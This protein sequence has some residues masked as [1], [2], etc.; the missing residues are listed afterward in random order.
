[1]GD[2]TG[3]SFGNWC[4]RNSDTGEDIVIRTSNGD[5]FD[6]ELHPDVRDITAE[7]PG[8][9]G[10]YYFGTTYGP[11]TI[12]IEIAFDH[13]TEERFRE[14]RRV[15]GSRQVQEL[16]FDERPYKK[17]LAKIG[18]PIELSYVCFDEPIRTVGGQRDGVRVANRTTT[19]STEEIDGEEVEIITTTVTREQV[20]PYV[21][22]STRTQRIYKGEGKISFICYF[23]FA[24]SVFKTIPYSYQKTTDETIQ[25]NKNYYVQDG[26]VYEVVEEPTVENIDTYYE[27]VT[28]EVDWAI[29]SGILSVDDYE[30]YDTYVIDEE[31]NSEGTIMIHNG[32]DLPTGFR[33]YLPAAILGNNIGIAYNK[34]GLENDLTASL[35]LLPITLKTGDIGVLVDTNNNLVVGVSSIANGIDKTVTTGNLYNDRISSGYFFKL[36]PE[37]LG[38]RP[39]LRIVGGA[40][41]IE[42][43]YD[44]LYF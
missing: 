36:E 35:N 31:N 29:S 25:A 21:Y 4:S 2:F 1:M 8:L 22:D 12:D 20:T 19:T 30:N 14:L 32:G 17:Y 33:L 26:T 3:F 27:R 23:P 44:Y 39:F 24:K 15:F 43:F 10:E 13:L 16:I 41:G 38:E 34:S 6:E 37:I 28:E 9:D 42:I 18:S 40:Q 5:R 7:V 11:K